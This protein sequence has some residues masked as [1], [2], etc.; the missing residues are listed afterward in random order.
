MEYEHNN[1]GE[2]KVYLVAIEKHSFKLSNL[3]IWFGYPGAGGWIPTQLFHLLLAGSS[4][5]RLRLSMVINGL[6]AFLLK[7]IKTIA[8]EA[9]DI[10]A[11]R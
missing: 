4:P 9:C 5:H 6:S 10:L 8:H 11:V 3:R 1:E 7:K 2:Y